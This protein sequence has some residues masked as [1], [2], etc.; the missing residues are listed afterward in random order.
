HYFKLT[1][2]DWRSRLVQ[3]KCAGFNTVSVYMP[4]NYHELTEGE[5]DF[6]GDRDVEY[7]LQLATELGLY[8]VARPGPYICNEWHA[9]GIPAWLSGKSGFRL[10]TRD[11]KF[12]A[13]VDQWWERIAPLIARY[14]LGRDGT[15]ILA[16]VENEYGHYGEGQEPEYVYH[17]R[18]GLRQHDVT[19]PIINCDSFINFSRLKPGIYD[20]INMC[21]NFGGDGLR[22]LERARGMQ[23]DAPLFVT[24]YWIAAF[25]WWGRD[26]SA[27]YDDARALNGALEIAAGGAGGL[28]AFVFAGGAHFGYW[29]GRSICSDANFMTTLYGPGAPILD[30]G[31]FSGK[32][33]LFK[34]RLAPLNLSALANTGMPEVTELQ[35]GLIQATRHGPDGTFVFTLNHSAEQIRIA[36]TEKDQACVDFS[37]PA[38]AVQWTFRDLRLSSGHTLNQ[39]N[40]DLLTIEPTLVLYGDAGTDAWLELDGQRL[41]AHVPDGNLPE[42][43]RHGDLD[44]LLLNRTAAGRC[45][46]LTLPGAPAIIFGGPERIE[47]AVV[48]NG[49]IEITASSASQ[50]EVW[51][52]RDGKLTVEPPAYKAAP[53]PNSMALSNVRF[54]R[55]LPESAAA[56]DDSGWY[57]AAQPQRMAAFGH[58]HGYAWYRT[59]FE[60]VDEGPQTIVFSGADDRAHVWIDGVYMGARGWG[61]N[62]GWHLMPNLPDGTH[63]LAVLIENLGMFNSGAEYDIPLGEP[64]GLYGPAWLNGTELTGWRMRTGLGADENIDSWENPGGNISQPAPAEESLTGPL[65]VAA[66][67]AIPEGF[68]GSARLE[69]GKHAGKGSVWL[70]GHN[71]GRYWNLGPQQSLWLPLSRLEPD[72]ELVLFEENRIAPLNLRISFASFGPRVRLTTSSR[73]TDDER[74]GQSLF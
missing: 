36:D 42:H 41:E 56:V 47:D 46:P 60:V 59:A 21:C 37:I 71:I 65:W 25:D 1:R 70:N 4:W 29:H 40:L 31:R 6:S 67:F 28:T 32:Y 63:S 53:S 39:T 23:P 11:P 58:G 52:F 44:I 33:E 30:D 64:K 54:S 16:Q 2:G 8:V 19:V 49:Q 18:D 24:E 57:S 55:S 13:Y 26:G 66:E 62:H 38:G 51:R 45:W 20:G 14:E 35:P 17:L 5:W 7:F 10:R 50:A 69:L 68:D 72:N 12:L 34:T 61:S 48:R 3:L 74:T 9:G 27:I 73:Q 15:I 22:C 43:A